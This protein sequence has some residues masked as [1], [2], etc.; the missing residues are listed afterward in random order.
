[1]IYFVKAVVYG[2]A[3]AAGTDLYSLIKTE[4]KKWC[5]KRKEEEVKNEDH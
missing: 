2:V 1:M 4:I 3:F 5:V